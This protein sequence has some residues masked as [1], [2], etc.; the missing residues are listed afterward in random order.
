MTVF[1]TKGHEARNLK[2]RFINDGLKLQAMNNFFII[3]LK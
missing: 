1:Y 2:E 3:G